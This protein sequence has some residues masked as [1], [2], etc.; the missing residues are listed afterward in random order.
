[1][2]PITIASLEAQI[3]TLNKMWDLHTPCGGGFKLSQAYGGVALHRTVNDQGGIVAPRNTGH[4]PKRD[5]STRLAAMITTVHL[6]THEQDPQG[7]YEKE[8]QL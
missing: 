3:E 2:K 7:T 1:M 5:L 4:I 8:T 6:L